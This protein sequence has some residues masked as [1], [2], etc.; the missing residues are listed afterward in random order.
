[1]NQ[2]TKKSSLQVEGK[3]DL[4][5]FSRCLVIAQQR[6]V[7]LREGLSHELRQVP[8]S[9][10]SPSGGFCKTTKSH[11]SET[12]EQAANDVVAEL[13]TARPSTLTIDGMELLHKI[14]VF[15]KH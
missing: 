6:K 3:S 10:S 4:E 14:H 9:I 13:F 2:A 1:M 7:N 8:P 12:L 15:Q 5:L 11:L